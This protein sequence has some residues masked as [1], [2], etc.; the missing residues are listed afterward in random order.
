MSQIYPNVLADLIISY[1]QRN[2]ESIGYFEEKAYMPKQI[3]FNNYNKISDSNPPRVGSFGYW[4]IN[5]SGISLEREPFVIVRNTEWPHSLLV[6]C[7]RIKVEADTIAFGED[8][9]YAHNDHLQACEK[10]SDEIVD[11]DEYLYIV[12]EVKDPLLAGYDVVDSKAVEQ[13]NGRIFTENC[14]HRQF[15]QEELNNLA[16]NLS[17][18]Q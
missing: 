6:I 17:N 1:T 9:T 15:T 14:N 11:L 8:L 5:N 10:V 3:V 4:L 12:T 13:T 2:N 18:K 7:P 16:C